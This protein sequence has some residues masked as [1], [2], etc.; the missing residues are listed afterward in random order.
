MEAPTALTF[1]NQTP[2]CLQFGTSG[3][4][5]KVEAMTDLEVYINTCGFLDYLLQTHRIEPGQKVCLGGDLRPSS[6]GPERSIMRAVARAIEDQGLVVS[7]LGRLPTP[8]LMHEALKQQVA[9]IMVTGSHIPFDRNGI[10]FNKPDGEVLKSD[11]SAILSCVQSVRRLQ[12]AMPTER[13]LFDD[14]GWFRSAK[15]DRWDDTAHQLAAQSYL[16]RYRQAF[17]PKCLLGMELLVYQHSA[18]GRDLLVQLLKDLGAKVWAVGRSETFVPIDT[19]DISIERLNAL[20]SMLDEVIEQGGKPSALVSTDGDSDRPLVC[21]VDGWNRLQ[22]IPGDLLGCLVAEELGIQSVVVPIS[23]NDGVDRHLAKHQIQPYKTRIGSP[24]VIECMRALRSQG[25]GS[26]AGWEAN[27]GFL[28]SSRI[29]GESGV[30]EPLETRDAMLPILTLLRSC[31]RSSV[32]LVDRLGELPARFGKAGL[33]DQ[34]PQ[35]ASRQILKRWTP[36]I[37]QLTDW[38][39]QGAG[40]FFRLTDGSRREADHEESMIMAHLCEEASRHFS[41]DL[42]YGTITR[43]NVIDG[44]RFYFDS[45]EIAH[46]RPSGNAPQLRFYAVADSQQRVNQMV[47][48]ALSEPA[49]LL[50]SME[51]EV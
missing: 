39:W 7:C 47:E 21:G 40:G 26:V 6:D 9:S 34:F 27:G 16:E 2:E 42:G 48:Q 15:H 23:T 36:P 46:I 17:P 12:Y 43:I 45:G 20:Q 44:V 29:Q 35:A 41:P 3:L 5:G 38:E 32:S 19:E 28:L 22:F 51:L 18:V 10:K 31:H 50:R 8:A 24:H 4:R 30:L 14:A 1:R 13:S 33:I 25:N 49:G 11:E 37:A